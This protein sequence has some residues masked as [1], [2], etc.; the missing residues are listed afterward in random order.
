M[1]S[2]GLRVLAV[3][4]RQWKDLPTEVSPEAV[5]SGLTFVG[6]V[7]MMDPPRGEVKEAIGLCRSAGIIPVMITGD[8]PITARAIAKRLWYYR[9]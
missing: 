5:E 8:H 6:L 1:A 3:G 2:E 7:G 9:R 4:M